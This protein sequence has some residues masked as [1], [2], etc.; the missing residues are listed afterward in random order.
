MLIASFS[1]RRFPLPLQRAQ[2]IHIPARAEK[3]I[4]LDHGG[5]SDALRGQGR[6]RADHASSKAHSNRIRQRDVRWES[7]SDFTRSALR[8]RPGQMKNKSPRAHVLGFGL[9]FVL[10]I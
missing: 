4:V 1:V 5:G 2:K 10:L 7:E 8:N 6:L 3:F 9:E